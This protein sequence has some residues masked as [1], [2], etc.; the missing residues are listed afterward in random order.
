V[1][2]DAVL[3]PG[4]VGVHHPEASDLLMVTYGNGLRMALRA[5]RR[6]SEEGVGVRVLDLRWLAPLPHAAVLAHATECRSVLVVDECRATGGGIA[7][8]VVASLAESMGGAGSSGG[9]GV[10]VPVGSVRSADSYV[11]LGPAADAVLLSERD[12]LTSGR[13][14]LAL[15]GG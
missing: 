2:P 10:F 15:A 6:L 12:V 11:P 13:R 7:D 5:A 8:A 14:M 9:A 3:L 1:D 4:E